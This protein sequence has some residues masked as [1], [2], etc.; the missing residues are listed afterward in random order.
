MNKYFERQTNLPESGIIKLMTFSLVCDWYSVLLL[1]ALLI[2][3]IFKVSSSCIIKLR[4]L[5]LARK[6]AEIVWSFPFEM[7]FMSMTV[8]NSAAVFEVA[9]P[10]IKKFEIFNQK[11]RGRHRSKFCRYPSVPKIFFCVP[12]KIFWNFLKK[13]SWIFWKIF[14]NFLGRFLKY[15]ADPCRKLSISG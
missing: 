8:K 12:K 15:N 7:C 5:L 2:R 1:R 10:K 13:F 14:W 6:A 9:W 3:L 4:N 11:T